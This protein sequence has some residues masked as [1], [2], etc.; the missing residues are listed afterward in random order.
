MYVLI[1]GNE[2]QSRL[3]KAPS[4]WIIEGVARR[5]VCPSVVSPIHG[6]SGLSHGP[7]DG[8]VLAYGGGYACEVAAIDFRS[9]PMFST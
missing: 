6:Y 5:C 1:P 9:F 7:D 3:Q 8:Q 2:G 4:L